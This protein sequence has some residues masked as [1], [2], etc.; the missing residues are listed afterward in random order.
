MKK[1]TPPEIIV[2]LLNYT[3]LTY[4]K[5]AT[6]MNRDNPQFLRDIVKGKT[7]SISNYQIS[8]FNY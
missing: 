4:P 3:R 8:K 5:F 7:S 2:S 1:L 6:K